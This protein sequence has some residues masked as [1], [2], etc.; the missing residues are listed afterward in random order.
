MPGKYPYKTYLAQAFYNSYNYGVLILFG[1]LAVISGIDGLS[2]FIG[3]LSLG[4]GAE[5]T[6]LYMLSNNPRFQRHIDSQL[7]EEKELQVFTLRNALW[8]HIEPGLRDR[9]LELEQLA[10][11]L[12]GDTVSLSR[13]K[14]P[15]LKENLRKVAILLA[16]FL[17]LAV[18]VTRYHNYLAG[19]DPESIKTG[20]ARLQ[21]ELESTTDERV[22]D[23]KQKNVDVLQKRAEKVD[24]ARANVEY[25]EAQMG[26]IADTMR[27][28]VD[29]AITLSDPKGMGLQIDNLLQTLQ[30]TE[31]VAAEMDSIEELEQGLDPVI[32]LPYEK[33]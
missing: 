20:I 2:P 33:Q 7:E 1:G 18:A 4:I 15:L 13:L 19:V 9:Y 25:L 23:I 14:D 11:R 28:V 6:F 22:T 5:I 30:D 31:L 29:Q 21:K 27:L 24:K 8:P 17:K 3:W 32:H 16:S 10:A 12:R 26:T